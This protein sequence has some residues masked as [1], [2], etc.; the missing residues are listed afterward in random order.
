MRLAG[1]ESEEPLLL[2]SFLRSVAHQAMARMRAV[3][4]LLAGQHPKL[5]TPG[6]WAGQL[7]CRP[8]SH[9][10]SSRHEKRS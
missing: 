9:R 5:Q 1:Q 4:G 3:C 8:W 7:A 10:F 2:A 6:E